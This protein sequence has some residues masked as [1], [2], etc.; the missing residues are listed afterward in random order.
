M[1][2]ETAVNE[3]FRD[4][5]IEELAGQEENNNLPPVSE[6][7]K[8][9]APKTT[10]LAEKRNYETALGSPV[11]AS[12][13]SI[14]ENEEPSA[15]IPAKEDAVATVQENKED[16]GKDEEL[17]VLCGCCHN[18]PFSVPLF[19]C[20]Q[21]HYVCNKCKKAGGILLSCP[22]CF[23]PELNVQLT[24]LENKL[25][26]QDCCY[27]D[28][29]CNQKLS[30]AFRIEHESECPYRQLDCPNRIFSRSCKFSGTLEQ[31]RDHGREVHS[32]NQ[33]FTRLDKGFIT[34]KMLHSKDGTSHLNL[35]L[36]GARFPPLEI[37]FDEKLFYCY[38]ERRSQGLWYFFI[39]IY[40][41][42]KSAK[43]YECEIS[44]A[45]GEAEKNDVLIADRHAR[46]ECLEYD[47][48][49]DQIHR[50]GNCLTVDDQA[51]RK[52][53]KDNTLF[54]AWYQISKKQ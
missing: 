8:E 24:D 4:P 21:G 34:C 32:L 13:P 51:I 45:S 15:K 46:V 40:G 33:S 26:Q 1:E 25:F 9:I 27:K 5:I 30:E 18:K 37:E 49:R 3:D 38:Y 17:M 20:K 54:R 47:L 53:N 44:L 42:E 2:T 48:N 11:G 43:E 7:L 16:T 10:G 41:S 14:N 29:G 35:Y 23:D 28:K 36:E 39:R 50:S 6:Q 22:K 52:M 19:G 12:T 31:V